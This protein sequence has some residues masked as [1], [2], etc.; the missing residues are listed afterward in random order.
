[1]DTSFPT[2]PDMGPKGPGGANVPNSIEQRLARLERAIKIAEDGSVTIECSS[3]TIKATNGVTIQ[4]SGDVI[5]RCG[6]VRVRTSNQVNIMSLGD[7]EISGGNFAKVF[8]RYVNVAAS[9]QLELHGSPIALNDGNQPIARVGDTVTN[10]V[11]TSG[12]SGIKA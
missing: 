5:T 3:L 11:I 6:S 4:S 8:G 10:G 9:R 7:I 12:S 1:M 2:R